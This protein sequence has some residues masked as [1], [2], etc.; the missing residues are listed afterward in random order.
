MSVIRRLTTMALAALCVLWVGLALGSAAAPAAFIHR[1][2]PPEE[3]FGAFSNRPTG[4]AVDQLSGNVF[5]TEGGFEEGEGNVVKVFGP[6]GGLPVGGAPAVLH[7]SFNFNVEPVGLAIDNAC[8]LGGKSGAA[9]TSFDPSN[10]DIYVPT[11]RGG[12]EVVEKYTLNASN[13]YEYV[14][15]FTGYGGLSGSACEKEPSR[16]PV[17]HFQRPLG[18]AVDAE[19]DVYIADEGSEAIYEFNSVGEE[20]EGPITGPFGAPDYLALDAG[21]DLFVR[22]YHN[23][24]VVELKRNPSGGFEPG[25]ELVEGA[26]TY[27]IAVDPVHNILY[28][29][30]GQSIAEYTLNGGKV[31]LLSEFGAGIIGFSEGLGVND[32]SGDIYVSD[33]GFGNIHIFGPAVVAPDTRTDGISGLGPTGAMLEGEVNPDSATLALTTCEFQYGPGEVEPGVEPVFTS[34]VPC[35][36]V[37]GPGEGYVVVSALVSGIVEP[38]SPYHYRL[39]AGNENGKTYGESKTFL[40]FKVPPVV[41]DKPGSASEVGQL[42][43]TLNGTVDAV[44]VPTSYHF[45]YGVT[46]AYGSVVPVPDQYVASDRTDHPV[47]QTIVG[48]TPGTTYHYALVANSPGGTTTG[49]D[50]TFTTP[51]VPV[52]AVLTGVASNVAVGSVTLA[53]SV[54]P[55]GWETGYYFEYGPTP[56]YGARW[57]GIPI[58]LGALTGPQ[59]VVS[60]IQGLL[61][62]T[63]YHYRLVASNPGGTDYGQDQTFATPSYPVSVIQQVPV[64]STDIGFIDPETKTGKV[65]GKSLTR[66]QKLANALKACKHKPKS[67]RAACEKQARNKYGP[68]AKKKK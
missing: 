59:G 27:G 23:G 13:E 37:P 50:E 4:V 49:P 9:C 28:L 41:D 33:L 47:T 26:F 1:L 68:V 46:S 40:S 55:Q 56:G 52:P 20:V 42:S 21:G 34:S 31:T 61:P 25:I 38:Y 7:G 57:P 65:T 5:A 8:F 2:L 60:A 54:D 30:L 16:S 35:S 43:A 48:L 29:D 67:K 22:G 10:G 12:G 24:T 15:Q 66:G 14:C 18:A 53:G 64:L 44:G 17:K 58:T 51:P 6:E 63:T 3:G 45:A 19:G 11:V 62:G 39:V 36:S 32:T